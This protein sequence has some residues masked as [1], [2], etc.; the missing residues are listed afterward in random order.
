MNRFDVL[1]RLRENR[2]GAAII[3]FALLAPVMLILMIGVF[4]IAITMQNYNALRSVTSDAARQ[5]TVAYQTG[6][7]LNTDEIHAMIVAEATGPAYLLDTDQIEINVEPAEE[8]RVD[9]TTEFAIEVSYTLDDW[10]PF[11]DYDETTL[12]Y[13]RP[14][15]VVTAG[16]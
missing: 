14:V 5:V 4:H 8:S 3:E 2:D 16:A 15:F 13:T 6:N 11:T 1:Q 9:G 10:M 12:T 7:E